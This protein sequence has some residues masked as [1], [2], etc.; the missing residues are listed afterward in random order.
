MR[1]DSFKRLEDKLDKLDERL[2]TVDKHLAV[3]NVELERHIEGTIQNRNAINLLK[4]ELTPIKDHVH[5]LKVITWSASG[6]LTI[7]FYLYQ[8]GIL[9]KILHPL[10]PK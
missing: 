10:F 4:E 6:L 7:L 5:T 8:S 1:D 9:L 2:D 3:Y